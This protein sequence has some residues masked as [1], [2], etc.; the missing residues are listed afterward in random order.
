MPKT[1]TMI[2]IATISNIV[3]NNITTMFVI[4]NG[5]KG[6]TFA[7]RIGIAENGLTIVT[8]TSVARR[9]VMSGAR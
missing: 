1:I 9:A 5:E 8:T 4:T 7:M 3:T 6:N 2:A